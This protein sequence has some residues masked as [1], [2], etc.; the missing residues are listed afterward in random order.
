[1]T[2]INKKSGSQN[3]RRRSIR[4]KGYDYSQVG[5]YFVTICVQHR[6][7]LFGNVVDGKMVLNE[8][9]QVV[10]DEWI[11]TPTLR[12][13]VELDSWVVMPNHFHGII[14]ITDVLH[15]HAEEGL[16]TEPASFQS[17]SQTIGAIVRG[18]KSAVTKQINI[19]RKTPA[20]PLWQRNYYEHIIRD[21]DA[22]N[23]I[24]QYIINN[25]AKWHQDKLA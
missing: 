8:W 23:R 4:L 18:F 13:N 12:P 5:A 10:S 3:H 22:L 14:L 20:V 1:M 17:P 16:I 11:K 2:R 9:G 7:H 6:K 24:R 21:E 19:M 25:P 15:A